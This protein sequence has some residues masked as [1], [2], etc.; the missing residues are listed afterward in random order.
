MRSTPTVPIETTHHVRD[1]C[2]C[3]HAQRAARVLAR[4]FDEALRPHGLTNEQFSLMNA[5]NRPAPGAA[6]G[7]IAALL[8]ADRTTLT[9]A[10]KPLIR[11]G[12]VQSLPDPDDGRVRRL[13]LTDQGHAALAGALPAWIGAH[14]ALEAELGELDPGR[15]RNELNALASPPRKETSP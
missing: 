1:T 12:L 14:A 4:R 3:L 9:A 6:L 15:V 7:Q 2:L 5:L 8:G 10:L 11:R 13:S